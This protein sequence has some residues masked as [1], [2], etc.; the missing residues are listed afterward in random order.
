MVKIQLTDV[1]DNWPSFYPREYN[2][3]LR[4]GVTHTTSGPIV[5]VVATD[6]DSG[7]FGT[8][9]YR[10]VSGNEANLFRVDRTTGEIFLSQPNLLSTRTQPFHKLNIS[11][12]DG[13]GLKAHQDAEVF[14][15]VTDAATR[16][17]I[18]ERTRYNFNAREDVPRNTII[19]AVKATN[20]EAGKNHL[21]NYFNLHKLAVT[22]DQ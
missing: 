21:L 13:G 10:I 1:N 8:V 14:L 4:E 17:P 7:R 12:T 5:V 2:V 16:P 18:F 19:G 6:Q 20:S 22:A 9:T 11:A 15:S 3:S